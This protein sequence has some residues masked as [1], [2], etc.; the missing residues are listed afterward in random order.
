MIASEVKSIIEKVEQL[1]A[2]DFGASLRAL[3]VS[4]KYCG[5]MSEPKI[6]EFLE[7]FDVQVSTGSL[8]NYSHEFSPAVPHDH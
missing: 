5:T 7:N 3:I 4:L 1:L 8:S 2:G 6:G